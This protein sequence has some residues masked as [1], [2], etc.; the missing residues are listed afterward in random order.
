MPVLLDARY[1]YLRGDPEEEVTRLPRITAAELLRA[2]G[3]D[4]W[5]H[6]RQKG[7]HVQLL[8]PT[9]PGRVTVASH[10]GGIIKAKTLLSTLEQADLTVD[11]LRR[12]L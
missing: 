10:T 11:D 5:Y 9:K 12:L 3:R 7:N 6:V 8:H 1:E 2:L 4:G